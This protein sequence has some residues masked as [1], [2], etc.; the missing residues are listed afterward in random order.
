MA[1]RASSSTQWGTQELIYSRL[2]GAFY[3]SH[4]VE[5]FYGPAGVSM[6]ANVE[7]FLLH[8]GRST[9]NGG[10]TKA[11]IGAEER[12]YCGY[13]ASKAYLTGLE[14]YGWGTKAKGYAPGGP[15]Y[16]HGLQVGHRSGRLGGD[17][18]RPQPGDVLS[19]RTALGPM[20]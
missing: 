14:M 11:N 8:L 15:G 6:P 18:H 12:P 16:G 17:E 9:G 10:A 19:V 1:S 2:M 13:A 5:R 3:Y 20:R 4:F 7:Y